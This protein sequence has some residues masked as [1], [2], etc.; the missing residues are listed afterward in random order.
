M[1]TKLTKPTGIALG[2]VACVSFLGTAMPQ[3]P[4]GEIHGVLQ[5]M[6]SP[7]VH[8]ELR[9]DQAGS[10]VQ[11]SDAVNLLVL[12]PSRRSAFEFRAL[13]PG[14]YFVRAPSQDD[15]GGPSERVLWVRSGES[16]VWK[17][18]PL[19]CPELAQGPRPSHEA[20]AEVTRIALSADRNDKADAEFDLLIDGVP[21]LSLKN[22]PA[23]ARLVTRTELGMIAGRDSRGMASYVYLDI[24]PLGACVS[25]TVG[26]GTVLSDP[27]LINFGF[28]SRTYLFKRNGAYWDFDSS[29]QS[30]S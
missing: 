4:T 20:V 29:G 10:A 12:P 23:T 1:S 22:L 11:T 16:T 2:V 25:A 28:S 15:W 8:V 14:P 6:L 5:R 7:I 9:T 19:A 30:V 17:W 24:Q 26:H 21:P 18:T 27:N 13:S 3:S